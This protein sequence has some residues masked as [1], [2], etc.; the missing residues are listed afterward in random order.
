MCMC[1]K[2]NINISDEAYLKL[3]RLKGKKREFYRCHQQA[4]KKDEYT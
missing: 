4:Y 3:A 2:P 1:G